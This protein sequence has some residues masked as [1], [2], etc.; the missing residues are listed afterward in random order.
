MFT[1][2]KVAVLGAGAMGSGI[3]AHLVGAGIP[4]CLLDIVPTE[5][6]DNEK[7][8]GL[9]L[10]SKAVRNRFAQSGKDRVLKPGNRAIYDIGLG[11]MIQVGNLTDDWELLKEADWIIEAVVEKLEIKK[12][13][14]NQINR[15]RHPG[16]IV[17]SNT[18]G[19]S[20]NRIVEGLP[21]ELRQHFLGT[22]F[23]NPPRWMKLLELIPSNDCL[24]ELVT[25]ISEFGTKRLGKGIVMA[26]DTPNFIANRIGTYSY[27]TIV[28]A[29]LQY[30]YNVAEVD[31]ITGSVMGRPGSATFRTIDMVGIDIF[32]HVAGNI[33]AAVTDT[34]EKAQFESPAFVVDLISK[35]YLGDKTGQGMYKKMKIAN[36]SQ[37]LC[38]DY[39]Q[40]QYVVPAK[41][42]LPTVAV[43]AKA[44]GLED[45]L[46]ALVYGTEKDSK[47]AWE[48]TKKL[49]L[50]AA[51]K[52]PE[53]AGDYKDI[54]KAMMW[55]YNWEVGPFAFW[56]AIGVERSVLR[57]Q[58]E[59]E[60]IPEWVQEMLAKGKGKFYEGETN[61]TPYI[62]L[63]ANK[64]TKVLG[65]QEASLIHIGD[66]V[67]CLE[68]HSKGNAIT[69]N[70]I[71]MIAASIETVKNN[72]A[73]MI[74]GSQNKNF[75]VGA[76]LALIGELAQNKKWNHLEELVE[77]FQTA[78]ML[79]KYSTKPVVAAPYNMT[80]G[81]GAEIVMH[82]H[83][84][85]AHA[86][87]YMGLVEVAVGLIPGGG[88]TKE[89]LIHSTYDTGQAGGD[90]LPGLRKAWEAIATAKVST[91][92]LDAIKQGYLRK[93]DQIV[94][95]ADYL[96][97]AAKQQ[98]LYLAGSNFRQIQKKDIKVSGTTGKAALQYI[99]DFMRNGNFI[100]PYDA[101]IANKV[102]T[103]LSG[104]DVTYGVY[105]SEE[106]ILELEKEAFVSLCGQ[107]KTLQ[108]IENMLLTGKPLRN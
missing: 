56:D 9:T 37:T 35:G 106:Q 27:A 45:K 18:S 19:V 38:W 30:G 80:V 66:N 98:V 50:Y 21:L 72:F 14:L 51:D 2:N 43:A 89:M 39:Q 79:L 22:H 36:G 6:T 58:E 69:D 16:T 49:L 55:G 10:D 87:T 41:G 42:E 105:R 53:I 83:S 65:N 77:R 70:V 5:L 32:H 4:V 17:S 54:D 85:T 59:G 93:S 76:N 34:A 75:C 101:L 74:V 20:I 108:R 78:N 67:V 24:P 92:G 81:G 33:V 60:V 3:A 91:S 15:Y 103:I 23:F 48:V 12:Q 63:G 40:A 7:K 64:N 44:K 96:I 88:G 29:M 84:A 31:A 47:F 99:I 62:Q 86:E 100:S 57:M 90:I 13:L 71:E 52:A 25:F 61:D 94:M 97:E 107:E 82:S 46:L 8:Q 95:N 104:G 68:F 11:A 26:K 102:A 28:K 73:G 1:I